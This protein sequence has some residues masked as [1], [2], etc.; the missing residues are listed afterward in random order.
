MQSIW[1]GI[2]WSNEFREEKHTNVSFLYG[3]LLWNVSK[4][5]IFSSVTKIDLNVVIK[6]TLNSAHIPLFYI[7]M[8]NINN[9]IESD[10]FN[11]YDTNVFG[12]G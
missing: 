3:V 7:T 12:M 4:Q 2:A 11:K 10:R 5:R 1:L 6:R 9:I 8:L